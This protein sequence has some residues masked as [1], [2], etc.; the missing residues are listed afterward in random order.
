MNTEIIREAPQQRLA[1][2]M[3]ALLVFIFTIATLA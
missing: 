1:L 2:F 3:V